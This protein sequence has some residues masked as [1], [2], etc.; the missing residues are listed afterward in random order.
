MLPTTESTRSTRP[1]TPTLNLSTKFSNPTTEDEA[2]TKDGQTQDPDDVNPIEMNQ[3]FANCSEED[4]I[5]SLTVKEIA[6]KN[7]TDY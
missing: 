1:K 7:T 5:F 6:D 2:T 3:V 4:E